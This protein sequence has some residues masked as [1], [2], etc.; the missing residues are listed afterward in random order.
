MSPLDKQI[1]AEHISNFYFTQ[2][3]EIEIVA[4]LSAHASFSLEADSITVQSLRS[5]S[6]VHNR[7]IVKR[8][9]TPLIWGVYIFLHC[10]FNFFNNI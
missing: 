1:A 6:A 5:A 3:W 7:N 4:Q 8:K 10:S 9:Y 2:Q